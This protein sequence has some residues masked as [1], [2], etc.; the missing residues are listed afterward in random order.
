MK[1]SPEQSLKKIVKGSVIALIGLFLGKVLGY[2]YVLIATRMGVKTFGL[3]SLGIAVTSFLAA[4]ASFG[5]ESGILRYVSFYKSR[6]N[7]RKVKGIIYSSLL[8]TIP[9]SLII[10]TAVFIFSNDISLFFFKSQEFSLVLRIFSLT[11][12]FFVLGN[13]FLCF[14]RA[15]QKVEYDIG[16]REV[17]ER[18]ARIFFTILFVSFGLNLFGASIAYLLS[19]IFLFLMSLYFMNKLFPLKND[20]KPVYLT[21]ELVYFSLPVYFSVFLTMILSRVDTLMIAYFKD[22]ASVGLYNV[23]SPTASLIVIIPFSLLTIFLPIVTSL[24]AKN[25]MS[26]IR[27]LYT[28]LTKWV[29]MTA[30][31]ITLL[32][33][34]FSKQVID[35]M[36]GKEYLSASLALII[37][38][39]GNLLLVLGSPS[40]LI[41]NMY[42]KT[43][44]IFYSNFSLV[45][46]DVILNYFFIPLYGINGAALATAISISVLTLIIIFFAVKSIKINPFNKKSLYILFSGFISFIIIYLVNYQIFVPLN[47]SRISKLFLIPLI[48]IISYTGLLI[49]LKTFE[50]EDKMILSS[51]LTKTNQKVQTVL[52]IFRL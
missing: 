11:I 32:L 39:I 3:I 42:K 16:T 5:L 43:K 28:V 19:S 36:F 17:G 49:L 1:K 8:I 26:H 2:I 24:Y 6:E 31:P 52:S 30:F 10:T 47:F 46:V 40:S 13:L 27:K 51:I 21:K 15:Y 9:A 44:I 20:I 33:I 18:A 50:K 14:T 37:L 23:A 34:F 48:F 29:L 38:S 25:S 45:V 4:I 41:L 22:I 35:I 7:L 12:P